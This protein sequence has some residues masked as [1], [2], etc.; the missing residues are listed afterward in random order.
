M[1]TE[2]AANKKAG[3]AAYKL[4]DV[5]N[6]ALTIDVVTEAKDAAILLQSF[7]DFT[8]PQEVFRFAKVGFVVVQLPVGRWRCSWSDDG[9]IWHRH[10]ALDISFQPK[11]AEFNWNLDG[12]SIDTK[13]WERWTKVK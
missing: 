10:T 12:K 2:F 1:I 13:V 5:P 4:W 7:D 6:D 3:A 11:R 8:E 9:T